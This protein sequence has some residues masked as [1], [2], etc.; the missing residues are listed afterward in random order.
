MKIFN[1]FCIVACMVSLLSA[2]SVDDMI[3]EDK[4]FTITANVDTTATRVSYT[5]GDIDTNT[6]GL[7]VKWESGDVIDVY[8]GSVSSTTKS[9][10][11][12]T[13]T[14][15]NGNN[16]AQF[17]GGSLVGTLTS[18]TTPVYALVKKNNVTVSE[19]TGTLSVNLDGQAGTLADAASRDVLMASTTYAGSNDLSFSFSHKMATI[20]LNLNLPEAGTATVKL[21]SLSST[22][23]LYSAVTL[24]AATGGLTT[25]TTAT[26]ISA[27]NVTLVKGDNTVYLSMYPQ[28]VTGLQAIVTMS[29]GKQYSCTI[30]KSSKTLEAGK[31]Y[32]AS[33]TVYGPTLYI[34]STKTK[35]I[36]MVVSSV[37]YDDTALAPGGTFET[38]AKACI[39]YMFNVEPY[40]TYKDYFNVYIIPTKNSDVGYTSTTTTV[41]SK[42]T[43]SYTIDIAGGPLQ[44]FMKQN[45]PDIYNNK[46][47]IYN[48]TVALLANT[49][50][51]FGK[52]LSTNV[53]LDCA[54][55]TAADGNWG[56][57]GNNGSIVTNGSAVTNTGDYKNVFLHEFAGHG[58]GRLADEYWYD[59]ALT[60]SGTNLEG[61]HAWTVPFGKNTISAAESQV[62]ST[63]YWRHMV[64]GIGAEGETFPKEGLFEGGFV[65]GKG[66]Y[67]P[68]QISVMDDNRP[69]FNA[70]SRQLIVERI[71]SLAGETFYYTNFK[72]KDVNYDT[73]AGNVQNTT[74]AANVVTVEPMEPPTLLE[75]NVNR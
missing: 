44:G 25:G 30:L 39:D 67:R 58:F 23:K 21:Q 70:Y 9:S 55:T 50:I 73:V 74:R 46:T 41:D 3:S 56:W 18:G 20:K 10:P 72:N 48:L 61:Y 22:E 40:K 63:Y 71:L 14:S 51:Y 4:G 45:C 32:S 68:E 16:R 29:T 31:L 12:F 13:L 66:V 60:Y 26:S 59:N 49:D 27:T 24:D 57:K 47:D 17:G 34:T 43:Y 6:K 11:S 5:Y 37:D 38:K 69:Y 1:S 62:T 7:L 36:T 53:G 54:V 42:K 28:A 19:A 35:P 2:C 64:S 52:T 33:R 15:G 8:T 75:L 65:Y